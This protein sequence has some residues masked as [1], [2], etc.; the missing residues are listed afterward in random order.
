[1]KQTYKKPTTD[2]VLLELQQMLADSL[3]AS[4]KPAQNGVMLGRQ[5]G[6]IWEEDEEEYYE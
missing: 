2:I 6:D 5:R 3:G 4:E 1:M